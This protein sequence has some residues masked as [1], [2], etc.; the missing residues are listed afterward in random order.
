MSTILLYVFTSVPTITTA[1]TTTTRNANVCRRFISSSSKISGSFHSSSSRSTGS[2]RRI[3]GG[4]SGH[5]VRRNVFSG[6]QQQPYC[7]DN[8]CAFLSQPQQQQTRRLSSNVHIK[9]LQHLQQQ[10][11]QFI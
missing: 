4:S 10:Q 11:R 2:S 9:Q 7:V 1:K 6:H 8:G 5:Q 3:V